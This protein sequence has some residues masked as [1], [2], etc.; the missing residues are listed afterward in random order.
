MFNEERYKQLLKDCGYSSAEMTKITGISQATIVNYEKGRVD[1]PAEKLEKIAD[2]LDCSCDYLLGRTDNRNIEAYRDDWR[3]SMRTIE[4]HLIEKKLEGDV[5][6]GNVHEPEHIE[7][8]S[9]AA[10]KE[11][12]IVVYPYNL[13]DSITEGLP[14]DKSI[15]V[16]VTEDQKRGLEHAL[17]G[18]SDDEYFCIKE[19]YARRKTLDETGQRLGGLTRERARQI[20][21][22]ALRKLRHPSNLNY[23]RYGLEGWEKIKAEKEKEKKTKVFP[24]PEGQSSQKM[25]AVKLDDIPSLS[26]RT[27]N[28]L[29]RADLGTLGDIA[30]FIVQNGKYW[31]KRIRNLGKVSIKE[32]DDVLRSYLG[33]SIDELLEKSAV[34]MCV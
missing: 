16:P 10:A 28:C 7:A 26:I 2:V 13:I 22:K 25:R 30:D 19:I 11:G 17:S 20:T 23:L 3:R 14:D 4:S 15:I 5:V 1:I 21:V 6:T 29:M 24:Q 32:I 27:C 34:S 12:P 8:M 18:L 9:K 33:L 31:S